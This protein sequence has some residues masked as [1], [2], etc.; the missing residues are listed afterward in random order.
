[1]LGCWF[2]RLG[3]DA[4]GAV[5]VLFAV[6]S[7]VIALAVGCG[8]DYGRAALVRAT[9]QR[10]VDAAALAGASVLSS[11]AAQSTA[12][13]L[14]QSYV[15]A[16]AA[17]L[18]AG[19]TVTT[20][21]ITPNT[22]GSAYTMSVSAIASVP[23]TFL[24]LY[25]NSI[26]VTAAA[27]AT[28][29]GTTASTC[30]LALDPTAS[31]AVTINGSTTV[32]LSN[33]G[34]T[35]DSTS[36]SDLTL[37]STLTASSVSL[38]GNYSGC[39]VASSTIRTYISSIPDPYA[40]LTMPSFSGCDQHNFHTAQTE[41][42][43]PGVYCGGMMLTGG[44]NVTLNPGTYI[45]DSGDLKVTGNATLTG[46]GV[47]IILTSSGSANSIG[48]V[49]LDGGSTVQL[50]APTGG[51]LAGMLIWVDR[52]A[53]PEDNTIAGGNNNVFTGVIYMPSENP[54]Y[55]GSSTA[56]NGCTQL[57]ANQIKFSGTANFGDNCS[58]SG[59]VTIA[60]GGA[61]LTN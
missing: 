35:V 36:A 43:D 34:L 51:S 32:D 1:M 47:T 57:V 11:P 30:V 5:A 16:G 15:S 44:A 45:L 28:N 33:C 20:T 49:N 25:E 12:T 17:S 4:D 29:T 60:S 40:S 61:L 56:S 9:L 58:G 21:T 42:L 31:G 14:S 37:S 18:P 39:C 6:L 59:V 24:H 23:T 8:V 54:T 48:S 41:T 7:V 19:A 22:G 52:N 38:G 50:A 10:T 46:N 3:R 13:T 2:R 55:S 26:A 53:P 27:M